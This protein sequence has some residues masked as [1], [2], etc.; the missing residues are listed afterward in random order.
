MTKEKSWRELARIIREWAAKDGDEKLASTGLDEIVASLKAKR[1]HAK[2][3]VA[4]ANRRNRSHEG[5]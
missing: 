2:A 5:I 4:A 3:A 1:P